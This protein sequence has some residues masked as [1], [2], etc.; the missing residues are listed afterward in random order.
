MLDLN[1]F[2]Q[3]I[4]KRRVSIDKQNVYYFFIIFLILAVGLYAIFN[5]VTIKGMTKEVRQLKMVVEDDRV[6]HKIQ[7]INKKQDELDLIRERLEQF[8]ILNSF[9]EENS[10]IN[11][12]LFEMLTASIP[13]GIFLTSISAYSDEINI[14]GKSQDQLLIAQL[15]ENVESFPIF[16]RAFV[17]SITNG[18]KFY[19]F[20]L[21]ISLKDV[22]T[23]GEDTTITEE[24]NN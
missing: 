17:S 11:D 14:I 13:E 12:S 10:K 22:S 18:D 19:S 21:D 16:E 7:E 15:V 8:E 9:I 3:Y 23:D 1:F 5:Q 2:D 20:I 4:V 24:T 6:N